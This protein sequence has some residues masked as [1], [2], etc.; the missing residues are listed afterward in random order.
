MM[1]STGM[2]LLSVVICEM[3]VVMVVMGEE[4]A[5][6]F[7]SKRCWLVSYFACNIPSFSK[8]ITS[9]AKDITSFASCITL[10]VAHLILYL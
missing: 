5:S 9:F 8:D 1:M 7:S 2:V 6:N 10:V 4:F 3:V